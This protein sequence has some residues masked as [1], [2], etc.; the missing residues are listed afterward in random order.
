MQGRERGS[1]DRCLELGSKEQRVLD[2][3]H[4]GFIEVGDTTKREPERVVAYHRRGSG[5]RLRRLRVQIWGLLV[6]SWDGFGVPRP[7]FQ[8]ER[9]LG[10]RCSVKVCAEG[11]G[12]R[13][14]TR[15]RR[16]SEV[17]GGADGKANFGGIERRAENR[18]KE[19]PET[20]QDA[21]IDARQAARCRCEGS[22]INVGQPRL[23]LA[24]QAQ[25]W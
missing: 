19:Q 3:S 13:R 24:F 2:R 16:D 9:V 14:S 1:G 5:S 4:S 20:R 8:T 7:R 23:D 21:I 15:S 12:R 11:D 10:L 25:G 17:S 6:G 22:S 18:M